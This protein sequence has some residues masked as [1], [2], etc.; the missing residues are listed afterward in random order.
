MSKKI[1]GAVFIVAAL[2]ACWWFVLREEGDK[3]GRLTLYGN[4]DIRQFDVSFQVGGQITRMHYEEGDYVK[5][6]AVMAELDD[7]D[8]SLQVRRADSELERAASNLAYAKSSY[9]KYAVLHR[10]GAVPQITYENMENSLKAAQASYDAALTSR[11]LLLRQSDYSK[12]TAPE[13]GVVTTRLQEP[14][15]VVGKGA[16]VYT[17]SKRDPVWVRAYI[18]AK[19]LGNIYPGMPA[20]ITVD[21]VEPDTGKPR[22]YAGRIGYISSVSEFTPK[23]VQTADLRSDLVYMIR[24]YAEAPDDFLRQG[25]PATVELEPGVPGGMDGSGSNK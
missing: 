6:G 17:L 4:V 7:A 23:T 13:D 5:K 24:V 25:M 15:M 1:I 19:D 20:K 3:S 11:N 14:G 8:Y 16:A 10:S 21:A 12:L 18:S 2:A 22:A 9:G